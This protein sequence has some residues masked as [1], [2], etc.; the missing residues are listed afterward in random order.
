[1]TPGA[2]FTSQD[3]FRDPAA[4]IAR[5]RAAGPEVYPNELAPEAGEAFVA[6]VRIAP[7]DRQ[8]LA[9]AVAEVA[10][11]LQE[12]IGK[13]IVAGRNRARARVRK[14]MRQTLP[15][16]CAF[17]RCGHAATPPMRKMNS[18]RLTCAPGQPTKHRSGEAC[19]SEK[20]RCSISWLAGE[21]ERSNPPGSG[22]TPKAGR[23]ALARSTG[24]SIGPFPCRRAWW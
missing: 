6:S 20:G 14:P 21:R 19:H 13:H 2:D 5:L 1:M 23:H 22:P 18:R 4:G 10:H 9:F 12:G 7:L 17:A 8:V 24:R 3:Y 15:A 11:A 16:G